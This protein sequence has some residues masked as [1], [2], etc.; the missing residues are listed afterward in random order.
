MNKQELLD[1]LRRSGIE[2]NILKIMEKIPRENFVLPQDKK[3]AYSN[4]PL[5]ICEGQTIS[6]PLTVALMTQWLDVQ[7]GQKILEAGSGSG[8]QA[9]ILSEMAGT[10]GKVITYEI[11]KR[12]YE[13]ARNNLMDYKNVKIIHGNP[14]KMEQKMKFDRVIVTASATKMP[15]SLLGCLKDGGKMVVPIGDEMYLIEKHG[16]KIKKE[17]KGYF[18]FVPLIE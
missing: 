16:D 2:E 18:S 17:M 8:Y 6:Q 12:L 5:E 10:E 11:R 14:V 1:E 15:E 7:E 3:Y 4:Y 13:F 9:V